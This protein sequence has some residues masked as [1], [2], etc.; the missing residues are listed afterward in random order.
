MFKNKALAEAGIERFLLWGESQFSAI[1]CEPF[2]L[3]FLYLI[4]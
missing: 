4:S 1:L 3:H 2:T